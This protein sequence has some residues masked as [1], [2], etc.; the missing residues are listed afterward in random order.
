MSWFEIAG[1]ITGAV[2]VWLYVR[3][4]VWAWPVGI[5][6]SLSWLVLFGLSRL[7][8]D[9]GLQIV[10]IGLEVAGWYWWVRGSN[11]SGGLRVQRTRRVEVL[12]LAGIGVPATLGLWAAM[13]AVSDAQPL[14]DA[15]TTVVSLLAQY[16]LTRK[17]LGNW[18]LWIAVDVAYVVMY[19]I[20]HLYLTAALQPLFI[21]MSVVG[22][23][24]W[25]R[26]VAVPGGSATGDQATAAV[27]P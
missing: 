21:A 10:Y 22:L 8:L 12:L 1:F 4:N 6:N 14:P 11:R 16:M 3:E 15:T 9:M 25:R 18:Y 23:R 17:L 19:S 13:A 26:S 5:A 7:Y 2:S 24:Q 20:Q 27:T